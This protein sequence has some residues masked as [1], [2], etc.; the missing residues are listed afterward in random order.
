M[1]RKFNI[2][3]IYNIFIT[4]TQ[5]NLAEYLSISQSTYRNYENGDRNIPIEIPIKIADFYK[6][7]LDYIVD[8]SSN[9]KIV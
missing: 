1:I 3:L 2:F 4:L 6:V 8:K 5:Q 9:K 7:S